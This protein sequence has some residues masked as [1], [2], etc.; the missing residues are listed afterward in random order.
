MS[1]QTQQSV[2]LSPVFWRAGS[3]SISSLDCLLQRVVH[4][5]RGQEAYTV[6]VYGR[7]MTEQQ[8]DWEGDQKT[9]K[10]EEGGC[11]KESQG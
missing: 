6:S 7:C 2:A 4:I 5:A 9:L 11:D 10:Q 1:E 8:S 3:L